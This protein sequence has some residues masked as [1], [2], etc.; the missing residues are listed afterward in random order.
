MKLIGFTENLLSLLQTSYPPS[1]PMGVTLLRA[2][3]FLLCAFLIATSFW[4]FPDQL[5]SPTAPQTL[6][7]GVTPKPVNESTTKNES[8]GD[9]TVWQGLLELIP[10]STIE[11]AKQVWQHGRENQLAV[12]SVGL[13]TCL[14]SI[15]LAGPAR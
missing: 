2:L 3:A 11:D 12:I 4:E 1:S 8:T 9:P 5:L 13:L 6:S 14:T 7:G 10:N 15:F